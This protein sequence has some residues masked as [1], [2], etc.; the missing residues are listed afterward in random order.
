MVEKIK[1]LEINIENLNNVNTK[2]IKLVNQ[3]KDSSWL[4]IQFVNKRYQKNFKL[5]TIN[6]FEKAFEIGNNFISILK[7]YLQYQY[8]Q[9]KVKKISLYSFINNF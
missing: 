3:L 4:E 2:I 6:I 9:I 7:K 1:K 8:I 5:Y